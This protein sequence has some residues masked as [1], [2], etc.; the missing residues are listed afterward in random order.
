MAARVSQ[1]RSGQILAAVAGFWGKK[2]GGQKSFL[3]F[4][5]TKCIL[6]VQKPIL[7]I[8]GL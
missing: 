8:F 5:V 4:S 3:N 2:K 1:G 6:D 7:D